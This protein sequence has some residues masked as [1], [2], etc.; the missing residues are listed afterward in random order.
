MHSF[1][2]ITFAKLCQRYPLTFQ[3]LIPIT[4]IIITQQFYYYK[5]HN[6][7]IYM[8]IISSITYQYS[9][10]KYLCQINN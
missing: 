5:Q 2:Q 4:I 9:T 6:I 7:L 8:E 10:I 3:H 1:I